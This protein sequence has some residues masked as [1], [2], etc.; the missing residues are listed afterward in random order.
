MPPSTLFATLVGGAQIAAF[1]LT[2][3]LSSARAIPSN[4]TFAG[5]VTVAGDHLYAVSAAGS[6]LFGVEFGRDG[7]ELSRVA[8]ANVPVTDAGPQVQGQLSPLIDS[9][10][11]WVFASADGQIG[12][13]SGSGIDTLGERICSFEYRGSLAGLSP[14]PDG[15]FIVVCRNGTIAKIGAMRPN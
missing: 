4:G 2:T 8:L 3:G 7:T 5:A 14:S 15:A 10:G 1:D 6:R 12:S 11:T 13:V 9:K